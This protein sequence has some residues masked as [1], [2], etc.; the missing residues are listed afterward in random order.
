M[1]I[2]WAGRGPVRQSAR[3]LFAWPWTQRLNVVLGKRMSGELA[4]DMALC[5]LHSTSQPQAI[6]TAER[7]VWWG[8]TSSRFT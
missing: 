7:P 8:G 6:V 2:A 3:V 5:T 4:E 1:P